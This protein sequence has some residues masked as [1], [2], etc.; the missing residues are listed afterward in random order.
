MP[1]PF[2]SNGLWVLIGVAVL[3]GIFVLPYVLGPVLIYFTMKVSGRPT[4]KEFYLE[5]PRVP[6]DTWEYVDDTLEEIERDGFAVLGAYFLGTLVPNVRSFVVLIGKQQTRE[7]GLIAVTYGEA[8]LA[9]M[10]QRHVEFSTSFS[11]GG[12]VDTSNAE[13][14]SA[15]LPVPGR[16]ANQLPWIRD[17][18]RLYRI[19][20][21]VADRERRGAERAW[22]VGDDPAA[23]LEAN[24]AE[25]LARQV[26][27]GCLRRD[28]SGDYRPTVKSAVRIAFQNL[29]PF[30]M[31]AKARR[32]S[33]GE[34]LLRELQV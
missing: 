5:D 14:L 31:I 9:R 26:P 1:A 23:Y 32:R 10:R 20:R 2:D 12:C 11:A 3:L 7:L 25:E 21:T 4:L 30:S 27:T 34:K 17:V 13:E 29:W 19:H 28:A 15:F 24:L 6:R 33:R 8:G 22:K 16:V 18:R